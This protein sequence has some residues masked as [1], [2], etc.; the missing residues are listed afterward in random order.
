[1]GFLTPLPSFPDFGVF[2]P[3]T[4]RKDSQPMFPLF[5]TPSLPLLPP[6]F[7]FCFPLFCAISCIIMYSRERK[8][9][10]LFL[11]KAMPSGRSR[12]ENQN[13][14]IALF[15]EQ[16]AARRTS[17]QLQVLEWHGVK[18]QRPA[19]LEHDREALLQLAQ[20]RDWKLLCFTLSF[21]SLV[22]S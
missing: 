20:G 17:S 3:C 11:R 1:M 15:S 16:R 19:L 4:G 12:Y 2:D 9:V 21:F 6:F 22:F 14:S 13:F 10:Y 7:S 5:L 8:N 18:W